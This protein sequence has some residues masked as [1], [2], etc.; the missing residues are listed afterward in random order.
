MREHP[1][2]SRP[3]RRMPFEQLRSLVVSLVEAEEDDPVNEFETQVTTFQP[4]ARTSTLD[5]LVAWLKAN[6]PPTKEGTLPRTRRR[7]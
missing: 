5:D 3:T 6:A 2:A 1:D 4:K 7:L